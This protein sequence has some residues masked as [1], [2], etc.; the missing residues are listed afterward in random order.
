M[1]SDVRALCLVAGSVLAN[2]SSAQDWG[3]AVEVMIETEVGNIEIAV[4]PEAAPKSAR[5]FLDHLDQGLLEGG[6]FYRVVRKDNDN[7]AP[8]IEVIQGGVVDPEKSLPPVAHETTNETG[9][10][11]LDGTVSLGR[12]E[13]GSASGAAFF[14]T[15]GDQPSLDFGGMR[16]EDGLGFAAFG[17]VV[18][19]MEVVRRIQQMDATAPADNPY[20]QGQLL[21]S[22]VAILKAARSGAQ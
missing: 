20:V 15:I 18:S 1:T 4:Y 12:F 11:H 16:N 10:T 3:R 17:R 6:A 8:I 22:P 9:I 21:A 14:I 7:G 19:G 5:S 13:P 2:C